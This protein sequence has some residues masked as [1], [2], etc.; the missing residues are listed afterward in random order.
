MYAETEVRSDAT[1]QTVNPHVPQSFGPLEHEPAFALKRLSN[2]ILLWTRPGRGSSVGLSS[3]ATE[4]FVCEDGNCTR[5]EEA[6]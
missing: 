1:G 2:A 4:T 3:A 5:I 6:T